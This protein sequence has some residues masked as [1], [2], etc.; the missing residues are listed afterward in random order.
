MRANQGILANEIRK[1]VIKKVNIT[2]IILTIM[3]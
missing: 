1:R 2:I 3:K